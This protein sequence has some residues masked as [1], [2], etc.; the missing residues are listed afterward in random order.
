MSLLPK[1]PTGSESASNQ[2]GGSGQGS[3][4]D[5]PFQ[6]ELEM[7]A[8]F[9]ELWDR[10]DGVEGERG[11]GNQS[12]Y[13]PKRTVPPKRRADTLPNI[14]RVEVSVAGAIAIAKPET[15]IPDKK[16]EK[17][18]A[19]RLARERATSIW[20]TREISEEE[21]EEARRPHEERLRREASAR[22][23]REAEEAQRQRLEARRAYERNPRPGKG[24]FQTDQID[25][26]RLAQQHS[27]Q[28]D[29]PV[30][31]EAEAM[32]SSERQ[33]TQRMPVGGRA[34]PLPAQSP[35]SPAV[36]ETQATRTRG[37]ATIGGPTRA[38]PRKA[39]ATISG[40]L[41]VLSVGWALWSKPSLQGPAAMTAAG[42]GSS[43][44]ETH[45][46]DV[47]A[48]PLP[49][50]IVE[51]SHRQETAPVASPRRQGSLAPKDSARLTPPSAPTEPRRSE[52]VPKVIE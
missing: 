25:I 37:V 51:G 5:E 11:I 33:T 43:T 15:S 20:E 47:V 41:A 8:R 22:A 40:A 49:P 38:L 46:D 21:I 9:E 18:A 42:A 14:A 24:P 26:R 44:L 31:E 16:L 48:E 36:C 30:A 23:E 19:E 12:A 2:G 7:L 28:G 1:K 27:A 32:P 4:A 45:H 3:P 13:S 39:I 6:D 10:E 52:P 34:A 35:S 29:E 17:A 50:T